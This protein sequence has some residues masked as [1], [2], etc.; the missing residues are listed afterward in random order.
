MAKNKEPVAPDKRAKIDAEIKRLSNLLND[1]DTK[2]K[3]I[4]DSLVRNAAF[5]AVTLEELQE[6]MN[7]NGVVSEYQNGENQWGT[8][9]SPEVEI[10]NT[11]IKNHAAI[12]KQL[13]DLR[14][15]TPP[16]PQ[17]DGFE[18]FVNDRD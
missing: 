3:K 5:M 2:S 14:P 11:M 12:M 13:T 10:Y 1:V 6:T 9:K 16:K 18:S 17:D 7:E 4:V 8:K 15:K